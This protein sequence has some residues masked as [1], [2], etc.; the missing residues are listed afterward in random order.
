MAKKKAATQSAAEDGHAPAVEAP[1]RP[2]QK[3]EPSPAVKK[4]AE[5][6]A[7]AESELHNAQELY[8]KVRDQTKDK[9]QRAREK[10]IGELVD[11]GLTVVK[12]YPGPGVLVAAI[13]GFFLG[14]LFRR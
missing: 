13:V 12:K 5:A 6:V 7:R 1:D 2:E 3:V 4:A 9:V 8:R 14:R 11:D 10:T